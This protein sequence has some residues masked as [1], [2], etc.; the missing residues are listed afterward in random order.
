MKSA[1]VMLSGGS[2]SAT[3]LFQTAKSHKA[4]AVF[5][6]YGQASADFELTSAR[7]LCRAADVPLEVV[8]ISGIKHF[9]LGVA[10][11]PIVPLGFVGGSRANCPHGLFGV[12]SSY[13]IS[14]GIDVLVTG[15]Q[16]DDTNGLTDVKGYLSTWA[17][18][19][20]KLQ[21]TSFDFHFPL[22]DM[23]KTDVLKLGSQLNVPFELTR[24]CSE[25]TH[26]HCGVCPACIERKSAFK[27][28]GIADPTKYLA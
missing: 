6:D 17:Q 3:A 5:F 22:I 2:D 4:S 27:A 25:S 26:H 28:S 1:L 9:F 12:A 20:R 14:A 8:D 21:P 11:E 13:C 24:S 16:L 19:M 15:M 18:A 10:A 7:R 23:P